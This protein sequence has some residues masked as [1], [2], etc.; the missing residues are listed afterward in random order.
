MIESIKYATIA[1][2]Y[3]KDLIFYQEDKT[4]KLVE[5]CKINGISHLPDK[6]RNTIYKLNEEKFDQVPLT[7]S[8]ICHPFDRLFDEKTL[9]KF[10]NGDHDD[11]M[12]VVE[13]GIIKGV[14]HIVDYNNDFLNIEFYKASYTFERM[15]RELLIVE[16]ETNDTLID[17]MQEKASTNKFWKNRYYQCMPTDKG[18]R[19]QL[20][21]KRKDLKEF[22]TFYLNDLLLFSAS[23]KLV[24][25]T[26]KQNIE[27]V[28][29]VRNWV[30][31]SKDLA[32]RSGDINK[33]LYKIKELKTFVAN[34][35]QFFECYEE[36]E[37][38]SLTKDI[39][40]PN[41]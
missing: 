39:V 20:I 22:Q 8:L 11:V 14:V 4:K 1:N 10:E 6:D 35:N 12:F 36:L 5:F 28:K 3:V 21:K 32:Y 37:F 33:P 25:K 23:K 9:N 24:S 30:A 27:A 15:L 16:G 41:F 40:K 38:K 17:W 7:E 34:A 31:H 29:Q 13:D 2:I 19:E 18:K 26:F